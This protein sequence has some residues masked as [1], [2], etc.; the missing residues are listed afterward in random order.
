MRHHRNTR[1][2][3]ALALA[4]GITID[5][6]RYYERVGLLPKPER[7]NGGFRM[8]PPETV[9]R[10]RF[11]RQAQAMGLS[12]RDIRELVQPQDDRCSTMRSAIA[13][14]LAAVDALLRELASFRRTLQNALEQCEQTVG[15]SRRAGCPMAGR[16]AT[17]ARLT[18]ASG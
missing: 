2:I 5:T 6:L 17:G 9:L 16:L 7:T 3:G 15:R 10:L 14:H 4:T 11:I 18:V 1:R 13:T 12:L 8:Y